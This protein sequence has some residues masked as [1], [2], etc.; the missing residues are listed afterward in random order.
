MNDKVN[1]S[2]VNVSMCVDFNDIQKDFSKTNP[3]LEIYQ[4]NRCIK[5]STLQMWKGISDNII[6]MIA[7]KLHQQLYFIVNILLD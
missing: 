2:N 4:M 5:Q 7:K 1:V 3:L 6:G